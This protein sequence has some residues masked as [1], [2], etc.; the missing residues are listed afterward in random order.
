MISCWFE[1]ADHE[2]RSV[3]MVYAESCVTTCST[4]APNAPLQVFTG[5]VL[6]GRERLVQEP[7][8]A[9]GWVRWL[10]FLKKDCGLNGGVLWRYEQLL[11]QAAESGHG[12]CK[13]LGDAQAKGLCWALNHRTFLLH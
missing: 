2:R 8:N 13:Q 3:V 1:D 6:A 4:G 11:R 7:E 9:S 10:A 5:V 12:P